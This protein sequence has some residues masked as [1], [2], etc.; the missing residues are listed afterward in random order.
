MSG[1][2]QIMRRYLIV[3]LKIYAALVMFPFIL[4]SLGEY[5]DELTELLYTK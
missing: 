2:W 5:D 3:G 4:L 1:N